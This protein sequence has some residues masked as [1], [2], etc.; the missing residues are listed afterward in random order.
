[1]VETESSEDLA[2]FFEAFSL[3]LLLVTVL[4]TVADGY[5]W[6]SLKKKLIIESG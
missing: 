2:W 6:I 5:N 4:G 1:M 3:L